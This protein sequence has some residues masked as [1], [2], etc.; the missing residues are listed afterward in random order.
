M[1]SLRS[2]G[3]TQQLAM[4]MERHKVSVLPGTKTHIPES[5]EMV[6]DESKGY[7]MVFFRRQDGST[8]DRFRPTLAPNAKDAIRC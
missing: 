4:E 7:T 2:L 1:R 6:L 5:G 3:K 8:R